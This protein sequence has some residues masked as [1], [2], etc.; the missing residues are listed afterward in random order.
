MKIMNKYCDVPQGEHPK[1]LWLA[2]VPCVGST[3]F[4]K[5]LHTLLGWHRIWPMPKV[6]SR[7][8]QDLFMN[9]A[10]LE[11]SGN[12]FVP[13]THTKWNEVSRAFVKEFKAQV[14][15]LTRDL[16][17]NVVSTVDHL[18]NIGVNLPTGY[19]P[20]SF[21]SMN[22]PDKCD[23]V[24]SI[25]VPWNISFYASWACAE[26][27]SPSIVPC[28]IDYADLIQNPVPALGRVLAHVKE[29]RSLR[30]MNEA[31]DAASNR[32]D[33]RFNVGRV[34]RGHES[35][36]DHV[37]DRILHLLTVHKDQHIINALERI[38]PNR[39]DKAKATADSHNHGGGS[40]PVPIRIKPEVGAPAIK[41][42]GSTRRSSR[43]L[44]TIV[45]LSAH[46]KKKV[47]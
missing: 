11:C 7:R 20:E 30:E 14:V 35:L 42:I 26:L 23:L 36:P 10:F 40:A 32:H 43:G 46:A 3:W 9:K 5:M 15:I 21:N 17:D 6:F 38:H 18:S 24:A 44:R 41:D 19:I 4:S 34:G 28:Y 12:V 47:P 22:W 39:Y 45:T 1:T 37:K 2:C 8:E 29:S 33:T 16:Y 13:H 27:E 31:I 25:L